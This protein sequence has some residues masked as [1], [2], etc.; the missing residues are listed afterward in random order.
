MDTLLRMLD[1]GLLRVCHQALEERPYFTVLMSH[2][3]TPGK[4]RFN[5]TKRAIRPGLTT[6]SLSANSDFPPANFNPLAEYVEGETQCNG[7]DAELSVIHNFALSFDGY[8][9]NGDEV[10]GFD[11]CAAIANR[12][13]QMWLE[14]KVLPES[15]HDLRTC[16]FFEQRRHHWDAPTGIDFERAMVR[17]IR[18]ISGDAVPLDPNSPLAARRRQQK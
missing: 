16:L 1:S 11:N 7:E 10:T 9:N 2:R 8:S 13:Q 5:S 4:N 14:N 12:A 3:N 6:A 15:L 18:E 17:R